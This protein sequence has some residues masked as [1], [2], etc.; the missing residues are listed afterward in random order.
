MPE[1]AAVPDLFTTIKNA[2]VTTLKTMADAGDLEGMDGGIVSQIDFE[3]DQ[4]HLTFPCIV[5]F[6]AMLSDEFEDLGGDTLYKHFYLPLGLAIADREPA[7]AQ[8]NEAKFLK[9]RKTIADLFHQRRVFN[10]NG[11]RP[12]VKQVQ[13]CDV[14]MR[15]MFD[16]RVTAYQLIRSSMVLRFFCRDARRL[17]GGAI[18]DG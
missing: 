1:P 18:H 6:T 9:W 17:E 16:P 13:K 12:T 7:K 5:V 11:G 10:G 8:E 3:T 2:T 15:M 14:K 4:Q